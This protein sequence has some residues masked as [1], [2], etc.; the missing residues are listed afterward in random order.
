MA[1]I[2]IDLSKFL[3]YSPYGTFDR[4]IAETLRGINHTQ[5]PTP[6]PNYKEVYG[7]TFMT[8]PQLNMTTQNLRSNRKF[9]N[10]L[11]N[12]ESSYQRYVRCALDPRLNYLNKGF[13]CPLLD[14]DCAFIP[15]LSNHITSLSGWPDPQ[16]DTYTS[17]QGVYKEQYSIVDSI[18]DIFWSYDMTASFRNMPGDP[19]SLLFQT[20]MEY[21]SNVYMGIMTP[22]I[23]MITNNEIDYQTRIY[24]F[25]LDRTRRRVVKFGCTGISVPI[26]INIG[27]S[28]NF[29]AD[30]VYNQAYDTIQVTF[31]NSGARYND[32]II[33]EDFNDTVVI[34]KPE[35]A[36]SE[37]ESYMIKIDPDASM[38]YKSYCYPRID[39]DTFNLEWWV[40]ME[41]YIRVDSEYKQHYQSLYGD[42]VD[43]YNTPHR[44]TTQ[45]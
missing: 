28:F 16:L 11:T 42:K 32:P 39:P 41:D 7:L 40:T 33:I 20:W 1:E 44:S 31:R 34:F 19:A 3:Q 22:Y 8:R 35:M 5:I 2:S 27:E 30:K 13:D 24:R 38:F 21:I 43:N 9:I 29:E 36:E 23:D 45:Y 18:T 6:I 4:S 12:N 17:P 26:S 10:L 37:R 25:V 15:L 14:H